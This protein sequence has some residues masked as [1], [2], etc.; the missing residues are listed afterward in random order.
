MSVGYPDDP[1]VGRSLGEFVLRERIGE[2]GFGAVY[3]ATQPAL[4]REAVVKVLRGSLR[5][6]Q[7]ASERFLR[8]AKL[9]S[10]LDHPY[11]AHV[12]A[13]GV[14][15][16]GE[17]WIAMELVRGTP[18]SEVLKVQGPVALERLVQLVDRIC[19]VVH[20][21][22]EAG[23][24][25]RDLKPANVMVMARAGRMLPKLLDF[26][27]AKLVAT[28]N[29]GEPDIAT[30]KT[31]RP[32]DA[33]EPAGATAQI[34]APVAGL[35]QRGAVM[36]SPP[37][38]A[39]EQW[40]DAGQADARTDIYALGVLVY[41]SLTGALPFTGTTMTAIATAHAKQAPPPVGPKFPAA[42]D[43]VF[44]KA[45]A[46]A[47]PDRYSDALAFAAAFRKASGIATE[48]TPLPTLDRAVRDTIT[49]TA[50]QPIADAVAAI[51]AAR[52]AHQARDAVFQLAR[53]LVR[54]LGLLALACRSRV[55]TADEPSAISDKL[56]ALHRGL[57][58]DHEWLGLAKQLARTWQG[59]RDAYP[60][61]EL[62][63]V[64]TS[65]TVL[66][67]LEALGVAIA[68]TSEDVLVATLE[69]QLARASRVLKALAF[70]GHYTLVVTLAGGIAER[71]MGARRAQ[72]STVAV[73]GKG[74]AAGIP[75]LLDADGAPVLAL[76]PLFQ[77]AAPTP[78]AAL[79]LFLFEGRDARGARFTAL[80]A[81]FEHHDDEL[82]DWF[83]AQI[84][85]TLDDAEA[86]VAEEQPPYRG[87]RAFSSQDGS[88]FFGREKQVDAF[89]NRLKQQ[90]LLAVVGRS[91]AGKSSFVYAG[92]VP[93]LPAGWRV[94]SLRPGSAPLATLVARLEHAGIPSDAQ[95]PDALRASTSGRIPTPLPI[96]DLHTAIARDRNALGA[97][98]RADAVARGPILLVIDQLEELFTLCQDP[99]ERR[100]FAEAV[101]AAARDINDP[102]RVIFT[103]RDDFLVRT[104]QVPA[105]RNRIGRA[106]S[107]SPCRTAMSSCASSSSRRA[108]SATSSRP[109]SRGTWSRKSPDRRARYRC[110]RSP[111][112]SC[113]SCATATSS[114]SPARPTRPSAASAA[115][116]RT[117]PTRCSKRCHS[118]NARSHA[119][120]SATSSPR[121][122]TRGAGAQRST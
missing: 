62:V 112:A 18:L 5:G 54:Y 122:C 20:S 21:A 39:P 68:A 118:R 35:T 3:R 82:W 120:R 75:A 119:K 33:V 99:D 81:A 57:L 11:A 34:S 4:D 31:L 24:V 64:L 13:F 58:P 30:G 26:G 29:T 93:A 69:Q 48:P 100:M 115:R 95:T 74:L 85:G 59:R 107:C 96:D 15:T 108:A 6:A 1:L 102:V 44:A 47:A 65:A 91:G 55:T 49:N 51:E 106:C 19:E 66:E 70:I 46:K 12:Y 116:S 89:S 90:A 8:E 92:V 9:A 114:S 10:K 63:D 25:H 80:P 73:R 60:I 2:G 113:G 17:L 56:R 84:A 52:N 22:H 77:V 32:D 43:V 40:Q 105:L 71:W 94:V 36:G 109:G 83:R 97:V 53:T 41:E 67:D 7:A 117:T 28:G 45:L 14:E 61:P 23:L 37:Y 72:R 87:L 121:E 98:L 111:P 101:A 38:M 86:A 42:L 110:C 88:S 103:L 104:E 50:P 78:G 27:I 76:A 16:D 79:E